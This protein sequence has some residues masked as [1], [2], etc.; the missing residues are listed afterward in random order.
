MPVGVGSIY[1]RFSTGDRCPQFD[2]CASPSWGRQHLSSIFICDSCPQFDGCAL[3]SSSFTRA[4]ER[5]HHWH[6][7]WLLN[8]RRV[9]QPFSFIHSFMLVATDACA[10][11]SM[12]VAT[13]ACAIVSMLVAT[14]ACAVVSMLRSQLSSLY[15]R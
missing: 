2:Y 10:I 6:C 15:Y 14:D 11:V 3:P 12:L 8:A 13:D 7:R 5:S 4:G 9:K 1:H